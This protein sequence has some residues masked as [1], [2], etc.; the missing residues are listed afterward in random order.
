MS[1]PGAF[2]RASAVIPLGDGRYG[3]E[4]A[5]GWDI[6]GNADGGYLLAMAARAVTD[7]TGRPDPV[8]ITAHYLAPGRAGPVT[9]DVDV[10]RRGRRHAT[11][12]FRLGSA[13]ALHLVGVCTTTDLGDA[14]GPTLVDAA[15]PDLPSPDDC[16]R[17]EP[18]DPFPP[19]FV[20]RVEMR[21]HPADV[22]FRTGDASGN[23]RMRGWF[24]L[25]DD[26]PSDTLALV[27]A[28]DSFPPTSFNV[29]LPVGWTPTIEL[30][31]HVRHRPAPGW[32]ACAFTTRNISGGYLET[33]GEIWDTSGALVAQSRQLQLIPATGR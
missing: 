28:V 10:V 26:E 20:G 23:A 12:T 31:A 3:G 8:T 14:S 22:P 19:P 4:V 33:D 2:A 13:D 32:L 27:L 15:P 1:E 25:R 18:G 30:T 17:S 6:A 21:I 16:L 7:A 5:P 24:R 29:N 11:G 9:V